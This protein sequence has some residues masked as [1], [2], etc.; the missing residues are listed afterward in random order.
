M[1]ESLLELQ[2]TYCSLQCTFQRLHVCI[3]F[4]GAVASDEHHLKHESTH[5]RRIELDLKTELICCIV[6]SVII[7]SDDDDDDDDKRG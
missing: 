4:P 6:K 1:H 5:C 2:R 7:I 3:Y